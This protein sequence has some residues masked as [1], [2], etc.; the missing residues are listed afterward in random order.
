MFPYILFTKF[1]SA[2]SNL[3]KVSI[4]FM[5]MSASEGG[6]PLV[7]T[8]I[9]FKEKTMQKANPCAIKGNPAHT[10]SKRTNV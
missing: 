4:F 5:D 3:R 7:A 8:K 9:V 2:S 6:V 10:L 1:K